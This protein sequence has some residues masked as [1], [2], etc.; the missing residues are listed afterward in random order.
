MWREGLDGYGTSKYNSVL[1]Y[2]WRWCSYSIRVS[3]CCF[4]QNEL[5]V[6]HDYMTMT[7]KKPTLFSWFL[8]FLGSVEL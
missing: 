2:K 4:R 6:W 5:V 1:H 8:R 7:F 3:N